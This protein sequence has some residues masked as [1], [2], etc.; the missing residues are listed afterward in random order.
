MVASQL[1]DHIMKALKTSESLSTDP[2]FVPIGFF[3]K[4]KAVTRIPDTQKSSY[5]NLVLG[6]V[7]D[8]GILDQQR[9]N[10]V[11]RYL[12]L[13]AGLSMGMPRTR[14]FWKNSPYYWQDGIAPLYGLKYAQVRLRRN[15]PDHAIVTLYGW[16]AHG[17]TRDSCIHGEGV[18]YSGGDANGRF[19]HLPPNSTSAANWL[20]LLRF[21]MIQ[22]WDL[23]HNGQFE[24][25]RLLDATTRQ[26][27]SD[28]K[29]L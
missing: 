8:T 7:I 6:N 25:L 21:L 10:R 3:G 13:R 15:Q 5:Y 28:G 18:R 19:F 29:T 17:M 9:E 20:T 2:D 23:D 1:N 16:L 11:F 12:D 27:L 26:W 14:P 4:D 22:E 24:T